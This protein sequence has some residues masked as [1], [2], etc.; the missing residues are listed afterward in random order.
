MSHGHAKG[1][2]ESMQAR[3]PTPVLIVK[4]NDFGNFSVPRVNVK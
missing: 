4:G 2:F 3:K 1:S